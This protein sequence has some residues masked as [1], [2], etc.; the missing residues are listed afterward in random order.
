MPFRRLAPD[1]L[2]STLLPLS[3]RIDLSMSDVVVLPLVPATRTIFVFVFCKRSLIKSGL[4]FNAICPGQVDPW[5]RLK[6]FA[7]RES[8]LPK[9]IRSVFNIRAIFDYKLRSVTLI[10]AT[11]FA[12]QQVDAY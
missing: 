2:W 11:L 3:F 9:I 10:G 6:A 8:S 4:T 5:P 1:A 7:K 12:P